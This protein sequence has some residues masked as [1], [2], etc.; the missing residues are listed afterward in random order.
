M[1]VS[2]LQED[3]LAANLARPAYGL[4]TLTWGN[5]SG[6]DRARGLVAIKPSG[7]AYD[8]W[9]LKDRLP[10]VTELAAKELDK[11]RR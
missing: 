10:R 1:T 6:I 5:A 8:K 9:E 3:V 11:L 7:V 4:V 2:A